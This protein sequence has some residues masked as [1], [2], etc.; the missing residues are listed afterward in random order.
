MF[1]RL[2]TA[3]LGAA[4]V[5]PFLSMSP[6]AAAT[7]HE[8]TAFEFDY[9]PDPAR[10]EPGDTVTWRNTGRE[11]HT[12][13]ADDNSFSLVLEPGESESRTFSNAGTF[14]YF[15][16]FHG[17]PGE[18]M[19][20]VVQVGDRPAPPTA[21]LEADDNVGAAIATSNLRFE[22]DAKSPFA[23]IGRSDLFADSLAS[24][25][26][27]G[28]L[29]APLLLNPSN[30]LDPRVTAELKRLGTHTAYLLGGEAALS[31]AVEQ[32]LVAEGIVTRRVSGNDRIDTANAIADRFFPEATRAIIARAF[33]DG[34]DPS[35]AFVDA[36]GAGALAA[37]EGV[38]VLFS[39][40]GALSG[41]TKS[42]LQL[43]PIR[44]VTL[45]GG[46]AALS[47]Q[48]E[49]DLKALGV[50]VERA[51]GQDRADTAAAVAGRVGSEE[52][53][54]ARTV[55]V[56][57]TNPNAWAAGFP[58]AG[59]RAPVVLAAGDSIPGPSIRRLI[60]DPGFEQQL[61]CAPYTTATACARAAAVK[62]VDFDIP[63]RAAVMSGDQDATPGM[64][65]ATG[66]FALYSTSDPGT[67]CYDGFTPGFD[68][69]TITG[70]HIHE[71]PPR[72][73]G[74]IAFAIEWVSYGG[75]DPV[76]CVFGAEPAKVADLFANP[77]DYYI[78]FHTA[79]F[80]AGALRGQLFTPS[81]FF[82]SGLTGESAVGAPGNQVMAG[83][84][85]LVGTENPE[86][87]CFGSFIFPAGPGEPVAA[88]DAHLHKGTSGNTGPVVADFDTPTGDGG[89]VKCYSGLNRATVTDVKAN[90]SGYYIEVHFGDSVIRGQLVNAM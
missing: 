53:P 54:P 8:V 29:D 74:P 69:S 10:I 85:F 90:G 47:A 2:V 81:A 42:Y 50:E 43:H 4:L 46:E 88:T 68:L 61:V 15:C 73:A 87:L 80:P 12:V 34:D 32:A 1:R 72:T 56:D 30:A 64:A 13:S 51:A 76:G 5:L 31:R 57:G 26:P 65:G 86:E 77:G 55:L 38:P 78:N 82:F 7:T 41:S 84:A 22:G 27:Q 67:F 25:G 75:N 44:S 24:G 63:Q 40:T 6:A 52:D 45:V 21:K 70:A 36:L 17:A 66:A 59:L 23:L 28:K 60:E 49:E 71:A 11:P 9:S 79:E 19:T 39:E 48:V 20:G 58:A 89:P 62:S 33:A 83:F 16:K 35:R 18:G 14:S 37:S 3:A